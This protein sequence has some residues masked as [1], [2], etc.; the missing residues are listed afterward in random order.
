MSTFNYARIAAT[1]LKMVNRFGAAV[2][3]TR[4]T[5]GAYNSTT[6]TYAVTES[7]EAAM[8]VVENYKPREIDGTLIQA[9]DIKLVL[10]AQGITEPS[11][12]DK[13]TL[14]NGVRYTVKGAPD[15]VKPGDTAIIYTLQLR[16]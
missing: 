9:G 8:G 4:R 15:I 10:A 12:N 7:T 2:T 5:Q 3:I 1:A 14:S 11:I 16:R 6:S 13:V